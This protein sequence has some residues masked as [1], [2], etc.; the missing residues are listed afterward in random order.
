MAF[1]IQ[2]PFKLD[3]TQELQELKQAFSCKKCNNLLSKPITLNTCGHSLCESC[4]DNKKLQCLICKC[5]YNEIDITES[6][7]ADTVVQCIQNIESIL[8]RTAKEN[9]SVTMEKSFEI[10]MIQTR[11]KRNHQ[12]E[13]ALHL[14]CKRGQLNKVQEL[15][16]SGVDINATDWGNW[17]PLHEAVHGNHYDC[18][19][20][21]L[22][23]RALIDIPGGFY[24]TPLH[25][26][27]S[28]E[29]DNIVELLL[30]YG[31][32]KE[33]ID[34]AGQTPLE[35]VVDKKKLT[36]YKKIISDAAYIPKV[37]IDK[38]IVAYSRKLSRER[39]TF[40]NNHGVKF[41][42][43]LDFRLKNEATHLIML[44]N[45]LAVEVLLAI[46]KGIF[47]VNESWMSILPPKVLA[48]EC[49]PKKYRCAIQN[50]IE[51]NLQRKPRL[52]TDINFHIINHESEVEIYNMNVKKTDLRSLIEAGGGK[53]VLRSPALRTVENEMCLPYHARNSEQLKQCCNYIIYDVHNEPVLMYNM[54]ELQHRSSKW[55]I[56]CILQFKIL[57]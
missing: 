25:K 24:T 11:M 57:D 21:L 20:L 19:E 50:S 5:P 55:L 49:I 53:V 26:A 8:N 34:Q 41:V 54:K 31:A 17:S 40:L 2:L 51:N 35:Y 28:C 29:K 43:E 36:H 14:A 30:K 27:I 42:N 37:Y 45:V 32:D 10:V 23:S 33:A 22:K 15:I 46:V 48:F 12:G 16:K 47:V 13:T 7:D 9:L 18:V 1:N 3:I 39:I 6:P 56:D 44:D 38:D 52:F 4:L